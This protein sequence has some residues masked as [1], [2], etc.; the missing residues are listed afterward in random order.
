MRRL[1]FA[2]MLF[3]CFSTVEAYTK[4]SSI[5]EKDWEKLQPYLLP[6]DHPA[7]SALDKIFQTRVLNSYKSFNEAGFFY[8]ERF[9]RTM[10][11]AKHPKLKGYLIKTYLDVHGTKSPD[12]F[13]WKRRIVGAKQIQA[14]LDKHNYN[15]IMKVPKKWIYFLP[16]E[17]AAT[18][19]HP[20]SCFLVVEDMYILDSKD[21]KKKYRTAMNKER[22]DALYT[23]LEEN[24]LWDSTLIFNIPFSKDGKIAFIDTERFNSTNHKM[25]YGRLTSKFPPNMQS[26]WT[27]LIKHK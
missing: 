9:N 24:Q 16:P 13:I 18:G 8:H 22:L 19:P 3:V 5:E 25:R 10:I 6:E 26:H 7:K 20:V 15:H 4:P 1:L 12:W 14:T 11:V 21:N 17:P 2:F 27:K 23:V